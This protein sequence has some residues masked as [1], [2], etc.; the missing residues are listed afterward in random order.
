MMY[1]CLYYIYLK[2]KNRILII[3]NSEIVAKGF[4]TR[5]G[6]PVNVENINK[7]ASD[8][9]GITSS[10]T[11]QPSSP[12]T[13]QQQRQQQQQ[14]PLFMQTSG[15]SYGGGSLNMALE[16]SLFPIKGLNPYQNK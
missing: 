3:L 15:N 6:N 13:S 12:A 7:P 4:D 2:K 11:S 9:N 8:N 1:L 5:F 14:Q 10:P 16:S